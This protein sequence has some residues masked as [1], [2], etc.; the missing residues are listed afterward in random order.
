[1][2]GSRPAITRV[3]SPTSQSVARCG[4]HPPLPIAF[5]GERV[6]VRGSIRTGT[7]IPSKRFN[8]LLDGSV[9]AISQ[10][11]APHPNPLPVRRER[12]SP[13]SSPPRRRGPIQGSNGADRQ[14]LGS[15]PA[16][17]GMTVGSGR[18]LA[19]A[20]FVRACCSMGPGPKARD[21]TCGT[22]AREIFST[23]LSPPPCPPLHSPNLRPVKGASLKRRLVMWVGVQRR[24]GDSHSLSLGLV[25]TTQ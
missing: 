13:R 22:A 21:D 3:G 24:D 5:N 17:A 18:G 10:A 7:G 15:I 2:A 25:W 14:P 12:A 8:A 6:G 23:H 11:A 9:S 4:A 19:I 20:E 1:M 16:C